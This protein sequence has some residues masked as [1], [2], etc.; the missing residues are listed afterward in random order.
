MPADAF[1]LAF[2]ALYFQ[3][4]HFIR[5]DQQTA[6]GSNRKTFIIRHARHNAQFFIRTRVAVIAVGG[7]RK[8]IGLRAIQIGKVDHAIKYRTVGVTDLA[9]VLT[10]DESAVFAGNTRTTRTRTT[11]AFNVDAQNNRFRGR[12]CGHTIKRTNI[13][14]GGICMYGLLLVFANS[15]R[16]RIRNHRRLDS[17]SLT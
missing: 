7:Y 12:L 13:S 3:T 6:L 9:A 4:V 16:H 15:Y 14:T 10:F 11:V 2:P 8:V 5:V 1:R 17:Y